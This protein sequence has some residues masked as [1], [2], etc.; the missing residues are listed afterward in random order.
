MKKCPV[1]HRT[2]TD[3]T[4]AFCLEDGTV[5]NEIYTPS[6]VT[7]Q[8]NPAVLF[9]K[10][11]NP[12][13]N[14]S[15]SDGEQN[16]P[17]LKVSIS[18]R[19]I[20]ALFY[21]I[22]ALGGA[23]S[24]IFLLNLF[25][26]LRNA[27]TAGIVAVMAGV[28]EAS[29]PVLVSLYLAAVCGLV[30]II[31]LIVRIIVETK[32][33]SPP[34]WFFAIGGI[35]CLL[36]AG[37]FWKAQSLVIEVLSPGSSVSA[38]GIGGVGEEI[39]QWLILSVIGAPV[40]FIL[41]VAASVIPLSS[42]RKLKWS[43]LIAATAIQ[44]LLLATAIG[45][46]FLIDEPK[47]KNETVNLPENVKYVDYDYDIDKESSVILTLTSDNELKQKSNIPD[48]VERTEN[49][50]TK[51]ELPE[52]LKKFS[53]VM[54]PDKKI[55]YLKADI[56]VSYENVLQVFDVIR[57]AE[58]SKVGLVVIGE[59]NDSD[60]YQTYSAKFEVKLPA[61]IDKTNKVV[62][63]NPLTLVAMLKAD[64]TLTLNNEEMGMISNPEKLVNMLVEVFK[65]REA[66]GVFREGTNET[67]KTVFL[68]VSK[69]SK[70]GDFIKLV[71]AVRGAGSE[72]IGIQTD[73]LNL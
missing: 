62:R 45:I 61:V 18:A 21:T 41:L 50:I 23:L 68:K 52:K 27:E 5:L 7:E 19:L 13:T 20:T 67:E 57:K 34:S 49:I 17:R 42:R 24:S 53:E 9:T 71:E 26:A 8:Y 55:V 31:V 37:L 11:E 15:I 4:T 36:P 14:A 30:V 63:P 2:Y 65:Q 40:V 66:T 12:S 70:Y 46:P 72:P 6:P 16:P 29:V 39:S 38:G 22:P 44:I 54:S 59:K 3:Q 43:P 28:K 69:S 1:C 33:A 25:R 47:R 51:E 58:I 64:G 73:D 35:L 60:P 56:N 32:T 10:Q 48:N